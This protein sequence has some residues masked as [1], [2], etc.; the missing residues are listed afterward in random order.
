MK[1]GTRLHH[2]L[3]RGS[4]HTLS[5]GYMFFPGRAL[6]PLFREM[7]AKFKVFLRRHAPEGF[8]DETGFHVG[9]KLPDGDE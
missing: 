2:P 4:E 6:L 3:W 8:E 5:S 9:M 7:A 1:T